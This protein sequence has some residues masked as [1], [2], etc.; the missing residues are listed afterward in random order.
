MIFESYIVA[1]SL[2][3]RVSDYCNGVMDSACDE[4]KS[5]QRLIYITIILHLNF[6][7]YGIVRKDDVMI[8]YRKAYCIVLRKYSDLRVV[9]P[10]PYLV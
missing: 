10:S 6:V 5:V 1:C 8:M 9:T 3:K 4:V 2:K 7:L